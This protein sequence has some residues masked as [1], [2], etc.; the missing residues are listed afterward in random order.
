MNVRKMH[1]AA[2]LIL[3]SGFSRLTGKG[4]KIFTKVSAGNS[5]DFTSFSP[6]VRKYNIYPVVTGEISTIR[7]IRS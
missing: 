6:V 3:L 5:Y 2:G 1:D 4:G 7:K